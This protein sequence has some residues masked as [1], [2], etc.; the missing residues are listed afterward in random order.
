MDD[1]ASP[2]VVLCDYPIKA[3]GY[4]KMFSVLGDDRVVVSNT[5]PRLANGQTR[6]A[7]VLVVDMNCLPEEEPRVCENVL[8]VFPKANVLFMREDNAEL[9]VRFEGNRDICMLGKLADVNVIRG[10]LKL[11]WERAELSHP[12]GKRQPINVRSLSELH[13]EA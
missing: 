7:S 9:Q 13:A 12:R 3:M 1:E 8:R 5:L 6:L 10:L 4:L 11:I 2:C